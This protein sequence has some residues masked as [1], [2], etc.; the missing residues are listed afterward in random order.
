MI[1]KKYSWQNISNLKISNFFK[2]SSIHNSPMCFHK[3]L[4]LWQLIWMEATSDYNIKARKGAKLYL[5]LGSDLSASGFALHM[6]Y[7]PR[8]LCLWE[9]I[10][11]SR[12]PS[13]RTNERTNESV[14]VT[15][16]FLN[17]LKSR[18]WNFIKLCK[19]L[20]M[21]KANNTYKKLRARG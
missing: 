9:G 12:C 8:K 17:I 18:R 20:H 6:I 10:L 14:S 3:S 7:T 1:F 16:C 15:F 4:L 11:F 19:N 13:V 2:T 21:Y 5:G